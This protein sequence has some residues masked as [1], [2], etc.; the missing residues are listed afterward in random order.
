MQVFV[1]RKYS[2]GSKIIHGS[3]CFAIEHTNEN[4]VIQRLDQLKLRK[5]RLPFPASFLALVFQED[6]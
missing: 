5:V 3:R 6:S 4:A 2:Q 1:P